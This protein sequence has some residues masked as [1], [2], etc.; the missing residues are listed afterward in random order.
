MLRLRFPKEA[1]LRRGFEFARVKNEGRALHG[2]FFILSVLTKD[3]PPAALRV[4]L[5]TSRRVGGAVVRNRVRRRLREIVRQ[6]RPQVREGVWLV[7]IARHTAARATYQE[8]QS[9]WSALARRSGILRP[10]SAS[11]CVS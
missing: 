4:G 8:L 2:K 7:L 11:E 3:L 1:R 5:I 9:E 6:A 10:A